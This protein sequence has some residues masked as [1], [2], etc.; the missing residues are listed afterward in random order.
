MQPD[1]MYYNNGGWGSNSG[2]DVSNG[3]NISGNMNHMPSKMFLGRST[4]MNSQSPG[5]FMNHQSIP[6]INRVVPGEGTCRGGI[7]ITILGGQF[8][9]GLT[10]MFGDVPATDTLFYSNT[11]LLCRLPPNPNPGAVVV[12]LKN[13]DSAY[14]P[15]TVPVFTYIDDVEK[16]LMALAL[17]VVGM[18]MKGEM[19]SSKQIALSILRDSGLAAEAGAITNSQNNSGN[20]RAHLEASLLACLDFIDMDESPHPAALNHKNKSG[21][22]MLHLACMLGMQKFSAALLARNVR[23]CKVSREPGQPMVEGHPALLLQS[24]KPHAVAAHLGQE[25]RGDQS[26]RV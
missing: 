19:G 15:E 5:G 21:Q 26:P 18:K 24:A 16:E 6:M 13:V 11:T 25:E 7:D 3:F 2:M 9:N 12:S 14:R 4:M 8:V 20:Q 22:T 1:A 17:T 23:T 10:V